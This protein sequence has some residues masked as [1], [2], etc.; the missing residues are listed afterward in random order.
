MN[1]FLEQ[2]LL[3]IMSTDGRQIDRQTDGQTDE[4]TDGQSETN[5]PPPPSLSRGFKILTYVLL[6]IP[7]LILNSLID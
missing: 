7:S 5:I 4:Q 3:R 2:V 6:V 1:L